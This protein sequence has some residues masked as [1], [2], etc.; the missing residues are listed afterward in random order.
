MGK[1]ELLHYKGLRLQATIDERKAKSEQARE[2]PGESSSKRSSSPRAESAHRGKIPKKEESSR[3]T[4]SASEATSRAEA[5]QHEGSP[6]SERNEEA[7]LKPVTIHKWVGG[8][9]KYG[10][11]KSRNIQPV[12]DEELYVG[13]MRD[14]YKASQANANLMSLGLKIRAAWEAFVRQFPQ[15]LKVAE[16]YGTPHCSM[17]ERLV[18]EWKSKLKKLVGAQAPP[19]LSIRGKWEDKSPL[20]AE[21]IKAW[22]SKGN[23]KETEVPKWIKEGALLGIERPIGTCGIFPPA[24]ADDPHAMDESELM[25]A[26][27]QMSKGDITNYK[28]VAEDTENAAIELD[29]YKDMGYLVELKRS[30]KRWGT[31]LSRSWG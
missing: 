9:G 28:S 7:G 14:P 4:S 23:D 31:E 20:D 21:I 24:S 5:D 6:A 10:M 1:E 27:T 18:A 2:S 3:S 15:V 16:E 29:R 11:L 19:A 26:A 12:H 30:R 25:D 8:D 13:G 22:A 17:D